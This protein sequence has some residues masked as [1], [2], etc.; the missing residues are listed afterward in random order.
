MTPDQAL[1]SFTLYRWTNPETTCDYPFLAVAEDRSALL[2][3]GNYGLSFEWRI[4][5]EALHWLAHDFAPTDE[6]ITCD[7]LTIR[8]VLDSIYA[9]GIEFGLIRFDAQ[10]KPNRLELS[11]TAQTEADEG[12]EYRIEGLGSYERLYREDEEVEPVTATERA[13]LDVCVSTFAELAS[14]HAAKLSTPPPPRYHSCAPSGP[15]KKRP[16]SGGK[17]KA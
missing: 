2:L 14:Q 10:L 7:L 4:S 1:T 13:M 15:I 9:G 5:D 16:N 8:H 6:V 12:P 3:L 17:Y 11:L